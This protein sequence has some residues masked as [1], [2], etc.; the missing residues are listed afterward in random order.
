M[1]E[2][3]ISPEDAQELVN[4]P[5]YQVLGGIGD[6]MNKINTD[7]SIMEIV[8]EEFTFTLSAKRNN[9]SLVTEN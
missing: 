8:T 7:E 4:H 3:R 9:G 5:F 6:Y 1:V 2:I